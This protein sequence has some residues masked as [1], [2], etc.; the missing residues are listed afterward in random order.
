MA[1]RA[2]TLRQNS[3]H[4]IQSQFTGSVSTAPLAGYSFGAL[5]APVEV[6]S[7]MRSTRRLSWINQQLHSRRSGGSGKE[8]GDRS[9]GRHRHAV[10]SGRS[11]SIKSARHVAPRLSVMLS[12]PACAHRHTHSHRSAQLIPDPVDGAR[13]EQINRQCVAENA[14]SR[15]MSC[16]Q[17]PHPCDTHLVQRAG[18]TRR[19]EGP[20]KGSA[21]PGDTYCTKSSRS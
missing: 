15:G 6:T 20:D 18:P 12:V 16:A 21:P 14:R 7:A 10:A 11:L 9:A 3:K 8:V 2:G 5:R 1:N 17:E 19:R 4:P 13:W